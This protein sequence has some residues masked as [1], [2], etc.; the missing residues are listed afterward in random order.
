[1]R[2]DSLAGFVPLT[3]ASLVTAGSYL[4]KRK[5]I[6]S[7]VLGTAVYMFLIQQVFVG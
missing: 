2:F 4:W 3:V 7:I 5:S 1:M 6:L